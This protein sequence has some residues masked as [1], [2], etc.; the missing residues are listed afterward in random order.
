MG[1]L[2][3]LPIFVF[4]QDF[5]QNSSKRRRYDELCSRLRDKHPPKGANRVFIRRGDGG[6]ICR[7]VNE[8]ALEQ[9]L[10]QDGSIIVDPEKSQTQE[11]VEKCAGA[12]MVVGVEGSQLIRG[13]MGTQQNGV[14][15]TIVPPYSFITHLKS[16]G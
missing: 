16:F 9:M 10:A 2:D 5:S 8:Q 7:L 3:Q 1:C 13:F 14:I 11:I 6:A 15:I 4:L 12:E